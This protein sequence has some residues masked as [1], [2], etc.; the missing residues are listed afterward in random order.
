M[1][2][3]VSPCDVVFCRVGFAAFTF[4]GG[5]ADFLV[6]AGDLE[7]EARER[8]GLAVVMGVYS[9]E[10]GRWLGMVFSG[11]LAISEQW[12]RCIEDLI[13]I[14]AHSSRFNDSPSPQRPSIPSN[15]L[16]FSPTRHSPIPTNRMH[17][18]TS[19]LHPRI[20][21]LPYT[22]C[23]KRQAH[24]APSTGITSGSAACFLLPDDRFGGRAGGRWWWF[25]HDGRESV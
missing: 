3:I 18:I 15:P 16:P 17:M 6:D 22:C 11:R 10:R 9:L 14:A 7:A 21:L 23:G 24:L 25:C 1:W 19:F 13:F 2:I 4:L 12:L 5:C 8:G 20:S